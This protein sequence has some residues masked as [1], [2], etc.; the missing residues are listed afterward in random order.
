MKLAT[1]VVLSALGMGATSAAV[2]VGTRP[3][4]AE[5]ATTTA[6]AIPPT[7][8]AE[9]EQ[10][11]AVLA[12]PPPPG[13]FMAEGT[14]TLEGRLGQATLAAGRTAETHLL[15]QVAAPETERAA[16]VAA[17][18]S[19][20]IDRSGSMKGGRM[21]NALVA[22]RGMIDRLRDGDSV[23]VVAY[24]GRASTLLPTT[25]VGPATRVTIGRALFGLRSGGSTCISCGVERALDL[26][27]Q[28]RGAV[29]RMLLLSDGEAN[30]GARSI[31]E[32]RNLAARA[33]AREVAI[34]SI[35]VDLEYNERVLSAL[36]QASD[37]NH[38]FVEDARQ[39]PVA[40][41][42][43]LTALVGTVA[44]EAEVEIALA[45]G[46]QLLDVADREFFRTAS[47]ALRVPMGAFSAGATKTVLV[48][49]RLPE[50]E[51][52]DRPVADVRLAFNDRLLGTPSRLEGALAARFA[53][54]D[55]PQPSSAV[56]PVV[57]ARIARTE[58][59]DA[60]SRANATFAADDPDAALSII[61]RTR[62]KLKKRRAR[63]TA[64]GLSP[65]TAAVAR[66]LD[67]QLHALDGAGKG[68]GSA[69]AESQSEPNPFPGRPP[70]KASETTAGKRAIRN[71][72][73]S[74]NP[75]GL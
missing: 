60:L 5:A 59:V 35:G 24:D 26:L 29:D 72:Q 12:A 43:E 14:L 66:D 36:A 15:V 48:R 68:F 11:Q 44:D 65:G 47:G 19:I 75:F 46:V 8:A 57:E 69:V 49:L 70:R 56:D 64:G 31:A 73:Q 37:G 4:S 62:S 22:A 42:H 20:V 28:R 53:G 74:I 67:D 45:D 30:R 7:P 54:P 3:A 25:V 10:A 63:A 13:Q 21:R 32:F 6:D 39:L 38:H 1:F 61:E 16:A 52:G 2:A 71:N 50:G 41:E 55:D 18:V 27:A 58:T 9:K 33:R 51:A 34:S 40:F 23:S 17:N